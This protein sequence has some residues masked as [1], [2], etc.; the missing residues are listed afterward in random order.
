VG[1]THVRRL[2]PFAL[3]AGLLVSG[4]GTERPGASP[5]ADPSSSSA[6][7]P[8]P[9]PTPTRTPKPIS[10]PA[11]PD[12]P[13]ARFPLALGYA[14]ENGD[15]HSPVV[16]TPEPATRAFGECGRT[17]W[18][19]KAGSSDVI[20]VAFNGEAEWFRGRTLVLYPSTD[21]ASAAV[22]RARGAI[23][24]CPRDDGDDYGWAEHT[25]IDYYAGAQSFGWIDRWWTAE[26]DGFDTGL[27]V[28][29]VA[30]VGRAVL[31][32]Y[33]YGE[34]NGSE[35]TRLSAL[36]RAAKADQPVVDAMGGI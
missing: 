21:A 1:P 33:E 29:H 11:A 35:Q 14:A 24:D 28:Y 19:P 23:T 15:D 2:V 22:D 6:P 10:A 36:T 16:V 12:G 9:T 32:S 7:T 25:G 13:L 4:C 18:D 3:A 8:T 30:R 31:L 17:V 26:T 34:A 27:T 5:D 20:G